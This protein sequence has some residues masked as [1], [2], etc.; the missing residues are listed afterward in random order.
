[1]NPLLT[2]DEL[3]IALPVGDGLREVVRRSSF[4][5]SPGEAFGLVGESGSGKSMTARSVLRL[6]PKGSVVEGD[7][8]FDGHP[9]HGLDA[10]E[11]RRLRSQDIAMIFQDPRAHINP[12]RRIGDFLCEALTTVKGMARADA[13]NRVV[14]LLKETGIPDGERRMEQYP[15][16]LSGG[17]LQRVM[18]V[19]ALSIEPRLLI[20]DEP[21]TAL[22]VTTQSEVMATLDELRRERGMALLLISHDL[23]L[24]AA[25]CDRTAV[26]YAGSVVDIQGSDTLHEQPLHPYAAAL[27]GSRPSVERRM[28]DL[29]VLA[30]RPL[31]AFEAPDGCSFASRCRYAQERCKQQTPLLRPYE[32]GEVACIRCEELY[33]HF[34]EVQQ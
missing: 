11:L 17:L 1:V 29:P 10:A 8:R 25:V 28:D 3:R 22:D 14:S 5:I 31:P 6:L 24:A 21:T 16:E 12:V 34:E 26:M 32:G 27:A 15:H 13:R 4:E 2:V 20:A 30:G 19:A 18:I 23:D 7:V 33:G 9:I